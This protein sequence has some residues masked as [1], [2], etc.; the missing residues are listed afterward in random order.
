[1]SR[2]SAEVSRLSALPRF[3]EFVNHMFQQLINHM[4]TGAARA[5]TARKM[6]RVAG[7]RGWENGVGLAAL[8]GNPSELLGALLHLFGRRQAN[9][10]EH[11]PDAVEPIVPRR[12]L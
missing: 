3:H 1:M 5:R 7:Q 10:V 9:Q 2:L 11:G 8:G 12:R 6:R 4:D